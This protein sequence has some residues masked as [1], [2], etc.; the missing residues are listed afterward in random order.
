VSRKDRGIAFF[1]QTA[2][3]GI[4]LTVN[5]PKDLGLPNSNGLPEQLSVQKEKLTALCETKSSGLRR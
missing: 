5:I 1:R 2:R 4:L 3:A